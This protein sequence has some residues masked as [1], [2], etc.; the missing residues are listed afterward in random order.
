[1]SMAEQE[2]GWLWGQKASTASSI[3]NPEQVAHLSE[4]L[5]CKLA[6]SISWSY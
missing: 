1:M 2:E 4:T 3:N 5:F 6:L